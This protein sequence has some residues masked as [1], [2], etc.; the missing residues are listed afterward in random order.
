MQR[1]VASTADSDRESL[2]PAHAIRYLQRFTETHICRMRTAVFCLT[3]KGK[4]KYKTKTQ[5]GKMNIVFVLT[6]CS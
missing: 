3:K 4:N 6:T 1:V 2:K 5:S